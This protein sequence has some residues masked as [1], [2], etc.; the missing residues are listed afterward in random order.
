VSSLYRVKVEPAVDRTLSKLPPKAR[1]RILRRVQDLAN[2]PRPPGCVK[3]ASVAD[4]Y[5]IRVGDYRIL[6]EVH[7]RMVLVVV[8]RVGHRRE[9]YR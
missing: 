7:D 1:D 8:V 9:V 6:Y 4:T 5:R 2:D 3:L